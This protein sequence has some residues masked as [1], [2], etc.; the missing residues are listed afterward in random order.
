MIFDNNFLADSYLTRLARLQS[1]QNTF[2]SQ[3]NLLELHPSLSAW[4]KVCHK[5]FQ[6]TYHEFIT[7]ATS[8]R[9]SAQSAT[10]AV[11]KMGELYQR[12]RSLAL[13]TYHSDANGISDLGI[14]GKYPTLRT[15]RVKRV[16]T[17]LKATARHRSNGIEHVL[18]APMIAKL[19]AAVAEVKAATELQ[20]EKQ[21][22]Y[23]TKLT[24]VRNHMN[25]DRVMLRTLLALWHAENGKYDASIDRLGMVKSEVPSGRGLPKPPE[26]T[27][28]DAQNTL[29]WNLVPRA[30]SYQVQVADASGEWTELETT[31]ET[32][33][34]ITSVV[35]RKYRV[36]ARTKY[37]Y[38]KFGPE[39]VLT[40]ASENV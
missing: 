23:R 29:T 32:S 1:I 25:R 21:A 34:A 22:V 7:A 35:G 37:G 16:E 33:I 39:V 20:A 19:E 26:S 12:C 36:R 11:N 31:N 24:A 27:S 15:E 10:Q 18:P 5:E 14:D 13:A 38:G 30:T 40:E 9:L 17:M 28:V 3:P 2:G 8:K 4:V 6:N